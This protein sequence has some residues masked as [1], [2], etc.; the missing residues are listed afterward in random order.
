MEAESSSPQQANVAVASQEPLGLSGQRQRGA[1][2][3][4]RPPGLSSLSWTFSWFSPLRCFQ[5]AVNVN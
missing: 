5:A 1:A 3:S 2:P 4:P